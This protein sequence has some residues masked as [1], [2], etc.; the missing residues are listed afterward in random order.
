MDERI[1]CNIWNCDVNTRKQIGKASR[2]WNKQ[3]FL[4]SPKKG[5]KRKNCQIE[6]YETKKLPQ[7]R[8]N[9]HWSE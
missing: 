5:N 6:F 8:E 7:S 9:N 1:K 3:I 4:M 2:Y